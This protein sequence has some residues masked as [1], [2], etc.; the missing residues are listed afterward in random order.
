MKEFDLAEFVLI[1]AEFCWFV[2]WFGLFAKN[3]KTGSE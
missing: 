3:K 1:L 2:L